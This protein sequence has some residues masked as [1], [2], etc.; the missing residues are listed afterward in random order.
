M[1]Q[2]EDYKL[3]GFIQNGNYLSDFNRHYVAWCTFIDPF[4]GLDYVLQPSDF[5]TMVVFKLGAG[6]SIA[7][8]DLLFGRGWGGAN[9]KGPRG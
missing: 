1:D 7:N 3:V 8:G 6:R 4:E 2:T 5:N 9:E